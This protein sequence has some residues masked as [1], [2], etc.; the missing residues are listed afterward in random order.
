[1]SKNL[2]KIVAFAIGVSIFTGSIV[3]AMADTVNNS[4]VNNG[5]QAT[6]LVNNK[7]LTLNEAFESA[8][9]KSNTLAILDKNI[10][11]MNS[12]NGLNEKLDDVNNLTDL[13]EDYNEDKR[14]LTLDKLE[15]KREFQIDKLKQDVTKAYNGLIV[16]S[17]E[18]SKLK[19]DI[20]LQKEEIEQAKLKRNLGLMTD[21]NIDQV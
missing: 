20:E 11:L 13:T 9:A 3:P 5:V 2:N 16:S 18:I 7:V 1:M 21:I 17:K 8:K 14:K 10:Q 12:I 4:N 19:S 15:Q 6:S